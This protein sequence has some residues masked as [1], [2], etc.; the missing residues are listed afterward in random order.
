[1]VVLGLRDNVYQLLTHIVLMDLGT[2]GQYTSVFRPNEMSCPRPQASRRPN[3]HAASAPPA[4]TQP[5]TETNTCQ[6][7]S[8]QLLAVGN[9]NETG[10]LV[11]DLYNAHRN[12]PHSSTPAP[13]F[14]ACTGIAHASG[15]RPRTVA[16]R[17][18]CNW[19]D[20]FAVG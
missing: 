5:H 16:I 10:L 4:P 7:C 8:S 20:R 9:R 15:A 13:A 17:Y 12:S 3:T 19:Y 1:M 2:G 11:T 6:N 14:A 18:F